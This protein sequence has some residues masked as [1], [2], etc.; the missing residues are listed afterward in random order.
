MQAD[1]T[2]KLGVGRHDDRREAH[3]DGTNGHQQID[4]PWDQDA[5]GD[6]DGDDVVAGRPDQV[7]ASQ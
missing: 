1:T 3:G 7:L 6:R 5:H 2:Q 4:A